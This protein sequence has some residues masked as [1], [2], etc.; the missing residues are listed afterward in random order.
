M[1]SQTPTHSLASIRLFVCRRH[2][3]FSR[4]MKSQIRKLKTQNRDEKRVKKSWKI[5]ITIDSASRPYYLIL[6]SHLFHTT[7]HRHLVDDFT[8]RLEGPMYQGAPPPALARQTHPTPCITQRRLV[9]GLLLHLRSSVFGLLSSVFCRLS[10]RHANWQLP[11]ECANAATLRQPTT[12][13]ARHD[14]TRWAPSPLSEWPSL[15]P[16]PLATAPWPLGLVKSGFNENMHNGLA[17][18]THLH[19]H[20]HNPHQGRSEGLGGPCALGL[21]L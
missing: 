2:F 21:P 12:Q 19:S 15:L 4:K 10:G 14:A 3:R 1:F 6:I 8:A 13:P 17:H 20:T 16:L 7:R 9:T 18:W 5:T 11:C